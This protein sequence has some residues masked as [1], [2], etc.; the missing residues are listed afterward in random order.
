MPWGRAVVR[1]VRC[2][3]RA[4]TGGQ[5]QGG[6][7]RVRE[8]AAE[9][10]SG[11]ESGGGLHGSRLLVPS[12]PPGL[13]ASLLCSCYACACS[14]GAEAG[15]GSGEGE[16]DDGG[17]ASAAAA[18]AAAGILPPDGAEGGD[19]DAD[20]AGGVDGSADFQVGPVLGVWAYSRAYSSR[21]SGVVGATFQVGPALQGSRRSA[22]LGKARGGLKGGG[23]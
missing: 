17:D 20:G 22:A 23:S 2:A 3:E 21:G 9:S 8:R 11:T 12:L 1:A 4:R 15:A 18:A 6:R 19:A 13:S 7:G 10:E 16:E 5:Q 14:D